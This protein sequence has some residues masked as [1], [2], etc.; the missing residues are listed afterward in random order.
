MAFHKK[1][2]TNMDH[3]KIISS[4]DIDDENLFPIGYKYFMGGNIY[5]VV[6]VDYV[7]NTPMRE[8]VNNKGDREV[9]TLESLKRDMIDESFK[10]IND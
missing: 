3:V 5:T 10:E 6:A 7:D 1:I 4:T 2:S 9:L 8:I